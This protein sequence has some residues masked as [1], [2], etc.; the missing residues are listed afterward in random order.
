MNDFKKEVLEFTQ[1]AI[2]LPTELANLFEVEIGVPVGTLKSLEIVR[3][4]LETYIDQTVAALALLNNEQHLVP[5]RCLRKTEAW[6]REALTD[7]NRQIRTGDHLP[8]QDKK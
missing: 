1:G 6:L 7:V 8:E 3:L 2:L 5:M 4:A